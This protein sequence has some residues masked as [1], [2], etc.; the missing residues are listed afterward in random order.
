MS[1]ALCCAVVLLC[2][3]PYSVPVNYYYDS[4]EEMH[5]PCLLHSRYL[6]A[7]LSIMCTITLTG[8]VTLRN[9]YVL[10]TA[11]NSPHLSPPLSTQFWQSIPT[12]ICAFLLGIAFLALVILMMPDGSDM[13]YMQFGL[14]GGRRPS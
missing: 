9:L 8:R 5:L 13:R 10:A 1:I 4:T 12:H 7:I 11:P 14:F 6:S 3:T 2:A